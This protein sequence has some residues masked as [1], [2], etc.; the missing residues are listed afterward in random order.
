MTDLADTSI[1]VYLSHMTHVIQR[2]FLREWLD[3]DV[4]AGAICGRR[5]FERLLVDATAELDVPIVLLLDFEGIEVATASFLRESVFALKT[6]L[7][8]DRSAFYP[9]VTNANEVVL[10]EFA[11]LAAARTDVFLICDVLSDGAPNKA[12]LLGR[13][14]PKQ[15]RAFD[16]VNAH[17]ETN[18]NE[19]AARYGEKEGVAQP[20]A[21][22]NRLAAL[23]AKSVVVELQEGRSKRYRPVIGD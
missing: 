2:I 17:G 11:T 15:K 14:D 22:N 10:E 4:L 16:L 20:T 1:L 9:V 5:L 7:R 3:N 6:R 18:A 8:E 21:W 23:H 19:L 13:L 12:R